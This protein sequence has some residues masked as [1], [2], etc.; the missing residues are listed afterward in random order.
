MLNNTFFS[1][2]H[3]FFMN[4]LKNHKKR[5][6]EFIEQKA[7]RILFNLDVGGVRAPVASG[8]HRI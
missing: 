1:E 5:Y 7:I 4:D 8:V 6:V 2:M 3:D